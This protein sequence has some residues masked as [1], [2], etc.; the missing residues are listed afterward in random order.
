MSVAQSILDAQAR[1]AAAIAAVDAKVTQL[2]ANQADPTAMTA[3]EQEA[4]A[5]DL[6]DKAAALEAI[7]AK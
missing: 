7:A 4:L 1:Q 2:L 6:H 5:A 3:A